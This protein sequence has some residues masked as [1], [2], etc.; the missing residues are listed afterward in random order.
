MAVIVVALVV[1]TGILGIAAAISYFWSLDF[2]RS[3]GYA[4]FIAGV[5]LIFW[6][7][8]LWIGERKYA[9]GYL[10][11]VFV[12]LIIACYIA[13]RILGKIVRTIKKNINDKK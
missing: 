5:F 12:L 4:G 13:V 6:A 3:L 8:G 1:I 11:P 7:S 10:T 9:W 2:A